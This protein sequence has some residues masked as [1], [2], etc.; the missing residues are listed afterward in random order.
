MKSDNELE[1]NPEDG[2]SPRESAFL[3]DTWDYEMST[4]QNL[5]SKN[6]GGE[7]LNECE[8]LIYYLLKEKLKGCLP[9]DFPKPF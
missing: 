5:I 4:F 7:I 1:W 2:L 8:K 9:K 6:N 3:I